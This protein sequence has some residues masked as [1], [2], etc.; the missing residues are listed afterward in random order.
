M[1]KFYRYAKIHLFFLMSMLVFTSTGFG[2]KNQEE[3]KG[4][5]IDCE[6]FTTLQRTVVPDPKP[7]TEINLHEIS[8]YKE[9]GYGKWTFG[10]PLK[11][12]IRTDIMP[13]KYDGSAVT[14]KEKLLTFFTISD[15]HITDK[16]APNQLIY[17]QQLHPKKAIGASLYSGS[18]LYTT[19]V[20][21]AT[22]QT[23][24]ALHKINPFDFGISLGDAANNTQYNETRWYIDVL[25][26]KVITPSSGANLGA[27]KIDYQKPFK[28]AGL[29][30]T[31]PWY[32]TLGNHDHF[33]VGSIPVDHGIRKDLRQSYIS[34]TVF[35]TGDVLTNPAFINNK[36]FYT[37]LI[38]GSTPYGDIKFAGPVAN[39]KKPP[40]VV[41]DMNRR[42]LL[43]TEWM[44]EFFN[45][46]SNPVGHGFNLADA[47]KGFACYSFIPKSDIP[48]KVIVLDNTQNEDDGSADIHGHGFLDQAR[49]DWLKKELADGDSAGQ[50]MIIAAHIPI[51][52]EVTA[53]RS[54]L[55]W[56]VDPKNAVTLPDLVA[57]LQNH[58]NLI[59]W[60]SGHRHLNTVK[61]FKSPDTV[62][63]PEKGFWQVETSSLR[64]FPQQFRTFE[65]Y[66][67]SDNTLSIVATNVDPAVKEGTPAYKSREYSV[68]A[69]QILDADISNNNPTK[70]P[71]IMPMPN[72]SYNAELIKQLTPAMQAKLKKLVTK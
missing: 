42:S 71:T 36:D 39:F 29:D 11:S 12:V 20:L 30:K 34:D 16:E 40:K 59:M 24:N 58:P 49:W 64:D 62:K 52:V 22:V 8:K 46:T 66:F 72:G 63:A 43:R 9:Y 31:I 45:T 6:V 2:A 35:A 48:I 44:K 47:E 21:D 4:Y 50:L 18:M 3:P 69:Q 68:A 53:P 67:N 55:G 28:S 23:I 25:D 41:A 26:G 5:P 37:G 32:Q 57:E 10:A 51:D 38:D 33:Y 54:E 65:I 61:A 15:I 13:A 7:T 19:Q 1:K 14:K 27:K 17:I 56:W 70:D 60:I